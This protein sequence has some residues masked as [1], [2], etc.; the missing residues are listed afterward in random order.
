MKS[1]RKIGLV[2]AAVVMSA[3]IV[4]VIEGPGHADTGWWSV[5]TPDR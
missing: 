4:A 1:I 5:T 3:G 2:L